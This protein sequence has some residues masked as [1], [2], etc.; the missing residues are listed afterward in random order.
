MLLTERPTRLSH[1]VGSFERVPRLATFYG[2]AVYMYVGREHPPP[3]FHAIYAEFEAQVLLDGTIMAGTLPRRAAE[4]T[5]TWARLHT[6][7]LQLNWRRALAR[8][9]LIPIEPLP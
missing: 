3:H 9:P 5:A 2:I 7:E 1:R 4:L 8:Q 6:D